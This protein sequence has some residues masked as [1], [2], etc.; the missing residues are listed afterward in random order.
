[1]NAQTTL[2]SAIAA[3]FDRLSTRDVIL[4]VLQGASTS[5]GGGTANLYQN[6][7]GV[8]PAVA[9]TQTGQWAIDSS[10]SNGWVWSGTVW[11]NVF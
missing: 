4:C 5:G 8:A 7:G 9:G 6:F 1:M 3:G 11:I 10:T 2:N